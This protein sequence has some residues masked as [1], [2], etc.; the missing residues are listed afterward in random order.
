MRGWCRVRPATEGSNFR[1]WQVYAVETL[2][3]RAKTTADRFCLERFTDCLHASDVAKHPDLYEPEANLNR[4]MYTKGLFSNPA[5]T[6]SVDVNTVLWDTGDGGPCFVSEEF[7]RTNEEF[8]KPMEEKEDSSIFLADAETEIKI[9]KRVKGVLTVIGVDG[10]IANISSTFSVIPMA[11]NIILGLKDMIFQA[12]DM[13]VSMILQAAAYVRGQKP[14][15]EPE[16][17]VKKSSPTL[18]VRKGVF[19]AVQPARGESR[20]VPHP[21]PRPQL[22]ECQQI[23]L[24]GMG[25]VIRPP[26]ARRSLY[27]IDVAQAAEN[28]FPDK[29]QQPLVQSERGQNLMPPWFQ[30]DDLGAEENDSP[31]PGMFSEFVHF[32]ETSVEKA[33]EEYLAEVAKAPTPTPQPSPDVPLPVVPQDVPSKP[34]DVPLPVA[35]QDVLTKPLDVLL[36]VEPQEVLGAIVSPLPIPLKTMAHDAASAALHNVRTSAQWSDYC[37]GAQ[38]DEGEPSPLTLPVLPTTIL[39]SAAPSTPA[40][41]RGVFSGYVRARSSYPKLASVTPAK[42][43]PAKVVK[44]ERFDPGMY[45]VPGFKEYMEKVAVEVFVPTN[46]EGIKC[47]PIEFNFRPDMPDIYRGKAR[48][49]NRAREAMVL[50]EFKRLKKYH[51]VPSTS[52]IVS[53]I[54]DADKATAPFV[55]ICGDYRWINSMILLD[56]QFIP[57]VRYEIE[58]LQGFKYFIDLDMVN[59]FHQ[60]KLG[61]KT[62][63]N[64]S[65]I[66]PWETV[67]P[68]FM[69]EGVSPATGVLQGHMKRIFKDFEE[70]AVV[71]FDN[72]CIG[73]HSHED[74]F[75]K[76]KLF[77]ARCKEYNIFL[78]MSKCYFGHSS[79]KFFGYEVDGQGWCIDDERKSAIRA[80][81]FPTGPTAKSKITRMQSFLGFSLYFR[82]F[83]DGYSTK[84]ALLYDMTVKTFSWNEANWTRDY[85]ALFDQF[86]E[87]MCDSFKLIFPDYS[88]PW[89]LQPDASSCGIGAILFQVRTITGADGMTTTRREPI[90]C[91]S[92]KFSDP[93]T[94]W[95]VIKQEMYAI[96]KS[97]DKLSYYLKH[98]PFQVQTDHSNLVQMEKSS[99][100]I[101]TR[102]RC[103]LQSFPITS[104][105]HI[106]G[107]DNIAADFLSRIYE[108]EKD[109]YSDGALEG[110][111]VATLH[112]MHGQ[113]GLRLRDPPPSTLAAMTLSAPT[114]PFAQ[115]SVDE[116]EGATAEE[117]RHFLAAVCDVQG[118]SQESHCHD[119]YCMQCGDESCD[120][121]T[122][123]G[124]LGERLPPANKDVFTER[125]PA[126]DAIL[127]QVHGNTHL[128]F[129]AL[130][131]WRLLKEECAGHH[132]PMEY[133]RFYIRGCP[134][135]QKYRRTLD[136]DRIPHVIRH[137]K[138]PGPRSTIG[139]DGFSVTPADKHGNSYMHVLVNH[140]TKHVFLYPSKSKDAESAAN[141]IITYISMFGRFTRLISDPG[142]DYTAEV[143]QLVKTYF[144]YEHSFSLV[145]RHESNGVETTNRELLRH[146]RTLVHDGRFADRWSE[147]QVLGLITFHM[148]NMRNSESGYSAFDC[149]FGSH[150]SEFFR[151]MDVESSAIT[152]DSKFIEEL[153]KDIVTVQ[154]A[155][156]VHQKILIDLRATDLSIPRNEWCPGDFVFLDNLSPANKLQAPRL[157]PY[158]VVSQY[159]NDVLL[160]D[161]VMGTVKDFHVDRLSLF[162]GTYEEAFD[163]AMRDR[164][165]HLVESILGYRGD[166]DKRET[167]EFLVQFTDDV[168]PVW[169][170]FDKDLSDTLPYENYCKSLPQLGPL[171]LS[172]AE[173][174]SNKTEL[175]KRRIDASHHPGDI[176]YVDLRNR[177]LYEHEW[178]NGLVLEGK[179]V[180]HRYAR[181]I[182]GNTVRIPNTK[183]GTRVLLIDAVFGLVHRAS[184]HLL[185]YNGTLHSEQ[186]LPAGSIVVDRDFAAQQPYCPLNEYNH[187]ALTMEERQQRLHAVPW[188]GDERKTFR[189]CSLNINGWQSARDK[190]LYDQLR[191]MPGGPPDVLLLQETKVSQLD[192]PQIEKSLLELGYRHVKLVAS[193]KYH[194]GGVLVASK[195]P[196]TLL[197][198]GPCELGRAMAVRVNGVTVVNL[199]APNLWRREQR[200]LDRR[201]VFDEAASAWIAGLPEPRMIGGDINGAANINR[202]LCIPAKMQGSPI[203]FSSDEER[204]LFGQLEQLGFADVFRELNPD[205]KAFTSFAEGKYSGFKARVDYFIA[206]HDMRENVTSCHIMPRS[207]VSDHAAVVVTLKRMGTNLWFDFDKWNLL[208]MPKM[209]PAWFYPVAPIKPQLL[210]VGMVLRGDESPPPPAQPAPT[211]QAALEAAAIA[212]VDLEELVQLEASLY[213]PSPTPVAQTATQLLEAAR[214]AATAAAMARYAV[215]D[216]SAEEDQWLALALA[217]DVTPPSPPIAI[218]ATPAVP[219]RPAA[220]ITTPAVS[221]PRPVSPATLKQMKEA[222]KRG[223]QRL[224][225]AFNAQGRA[226]TLR[227]RDEK[228]ARLKRQK[229]LQEQFQLEHADLVRDHRERKQA[230]QAAAAATSALWAQ[231][232]SLW[233]EL[234]EPEAIATPPLPPLPA[235][236]EEA[237][238]RHTARAEAREEHRINALEAFARHERQAATQRIER[239][240]AHE[241]RRIDALEAFARQERQDRQ[242]PSPQRPPQDPLSTP[243]RGPSSLQREE[244]GLFR[245]FSPTLPP[246]LSTPVFT[247]RTV[248]RPAPVLQPAPLSLTTAEQRARAAQW[249]RETLGLSLR[250]DTAPRRT[251]QHTAAELERLLLPT[252][253]PT[254]SPPPAE[255]RKLTVEEHDAAAQEANRLLGYALTPESP[256]S[257]VYS[258]MTSE[259]GSEPVFYDYAQLCDDIFINNSIPMVPASSLLVVP[260]QYGCYR[261][262]AVVRAVG[263]ALASSVDIAVGQAI[264]A[265]HGTTVTMA[266]AREMQEDSQGRYLIQVSDDEVLD[267]RLDAAARPPLCFASIANQAQGL[268]LHGRLLTVN[269]NNAAVELSDVVNGPP[270][271][272]LYAVVHIPAFQEVMW[273]YGEEFEAGFEQSQSSLSSHVSEISS[274]E[275][276]EEEKDT[277]VSMPSDSGRPT[278]PVGGRTRHRQVIARL[279]AANFD[280]RDAIPELAFRNDAPHENDDVLTAPRSV[281]N[282]AP[283]EDNDVLTAL[284]QYVGE[285][286]ASRQEN[287]R[288]PTDAEYDLI[289]RM[290]HYR[291]GDSDDS[292]EDP[293]EPYINYDDGW[294]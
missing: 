92:Q 173:A 8:F 190:G 281:R 227:Q 253:S 38:D 189:V 146:V 155:S 235:D 216:T 270:T 186:S 178:Y 250:H 231:P 181:L 25:Y 243:P 26:R 238:I 265:F 262:G 283:D 154:E 234:L 256:P 289:E 203:G 66:T 192:E 44:R 210:L 81:P 252:P 19:R 242:R 22:P 139:I 39:S 251:P 162:D 197:G 196:F 76:L 147:P 259:A 73:G 180:T 199:Y 267:C 286:R 144:G 6:D 165:Q 1:K 84:A 108:H 5:G 268:L 184:A 64:L 102:W 194:F 266:Q 28:I 290:I 177:V 53:P 151:A 172:A 269:H 273:S 55:R 200:M 232:D 157:G 145:D 127:E 284:P 83:V 87:D 249:A 204:R 56:H 43:A 35:P 61:R 109:V 257:P 11:C 71:I 143:A 248:V 121:D 217:V 33:M 88:L 193:L 226:N 149:T 188:S 215:T 258:A 279:E 48:P 9:S 179:D 47:E 276:E 134:V 14:A 68:V 142:S 3:G 72:F 54:S 93:A 98:K 282:D 195:D 77:L 141:A 13:L 278:V 285:P 229:E 168:T 113:A 219:R 17:E 34:P 129:G 131:T 255:E 75:A 27:S 224:D 110:G 292:V 82:D 211:A 24:R 148:N 29:A 185:E 62:S 52:S 125:V 21:K 160:R 118:C 254:P 60:F 239:A 10:A 90:A 228:A 198:T 67:R 135:C 85:R 153:T 213:P 212:V 128:H 222:K 291:P 164:R 32:M 208:P 169:K 247:P 119:S 271:A 114:G 171:L 30:R 170:N 264:A 96:F 132:I 175:Q 293:L 37:R 106:P 240:E 112:M 140:F 69:P 23:A 51:L 156:A 40:P 287:D 163:L 111:V 294:R 103:F 207:P 122:L 244:F 263:D 174:K 70:W 261:S 152:V 57:Q 79:V 214:V 12:P 7:L 277:S 225:A 233:A 74:L 191:A 89:I 176:I 78:K 223:G 182:V 230:E 183:A 117:R 237:A 161:L 36:P 136:K 65:V 201:A 50:E 202:D 126:F 220:M 133:V 115:A 187:R 41:R 4:F 246:I 18:S 97:V 20:R 260:S 167:M 105:I 221:R 16:P 280:S 15:V 100:G 209:N 274:D 101:I 150:Q 245:P 107:K 45:A 206:S 275:E 91:V 99:V 80:I 137:L 158:V 241:A 58:K 166:V 95:A 205:L 86:K 104:I 130:A 94:R 288:E 272:T 218:I 46:W 116:L 159:R 120:F 138:V 59:S 124:G 236:E 2:A 49:I 123:L 42:N 63:E 31:Y